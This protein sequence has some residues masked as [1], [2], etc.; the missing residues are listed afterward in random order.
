MIAQWIAVGAGGFVGAMCR[1]GI[2]L[3]PVKE[4]SLFPFKTC[5]INI[6]GCFVIGLIAAMALKH[7]T[8]DTRVIAFLKAGLC[9]GFTTFSS[10]ALETEGLMQS[11]HMGLALLYVC[12]SVVVGICAVFAGQMLAQ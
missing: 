1:Y 10:F 3:L 2:G 5:F 7:P 11:G 8:W 12:I 9:G 4:G 6:A